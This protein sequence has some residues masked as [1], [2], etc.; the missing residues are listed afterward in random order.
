MACNQ[1]GIALQPLD[2][3]APGVDL[4]AGRP[5]RASEVECGVGRPDKQESM[6][7]CAGRRKV[8]DDPA[9]ITDLVEL[10]AV[11]HAARVDVITDELARSLIRVA[12]L[13]ADPGGSIVLNLS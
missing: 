11:G 10:V 9:T 7:R 6:E 5:H 4:A 13:N 12:E 1:G 8:A 3:L 2:D